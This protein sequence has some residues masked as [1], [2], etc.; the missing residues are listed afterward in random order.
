MQE[1]KI[2]PF[3]LLGLFCIEVNVL[4]LGFGVK[5]VVQIPV[6]VTYWSNRFKL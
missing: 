5:T 2:Y 1:E 6:S 4:L 3:Y